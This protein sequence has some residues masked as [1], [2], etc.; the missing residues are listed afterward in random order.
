MWIKRG[1]KP[2]LICYNK[3]K[4]QNMEKLTVEDRIMGRKEPLPPTELQLKAF[5]NETKY[6]VYAEDSD[7]KKV[8]TGVKIGRILSLEKREQITN[9]ELVVKANGLV[10]ERIE[11]PTVKE[12]LTVE[13]DVRKNRTTDEEISVVEPPKPKRK[14][15]K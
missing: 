5:T 3:V 12:N 9:G 14:R 1:I 6:L 7:N 8:V 10:I 11:D 15:A 2:S 4:E 13:E